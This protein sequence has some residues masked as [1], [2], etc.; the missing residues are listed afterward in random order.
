MYFFD[1]IREIILL[2]SLNRPIISIKILIGPGNF[3][4]VTH[5]KQAMKLKTRLMCS[6][7]CISQET[8]NKIAFIALN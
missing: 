5:F 3:A 8:S 2:E 6:Y 4:S 7:T 1:F